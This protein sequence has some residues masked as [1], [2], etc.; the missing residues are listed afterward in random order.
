MP[1]G[2]LSR[3]GIFADR[4][5]NLIQD[6]IELVDGRKDER[7][8]RF[9]LHRRPTVFGSVMREHQVLELCA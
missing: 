9:G 5:A 2:E 6:G 4:Q 1:A 3:L 7:L 8:E